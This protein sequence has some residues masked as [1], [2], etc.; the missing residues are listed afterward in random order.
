MGGTDESEEEREFRLR[1][2][3]L[4]V[5]DGRIFTSHGLSLEEVRMSFIVLALAGDEIKIPEDTAIVWEYLDKAWPRSVNG[6]PCFPSCHFMNIEDWKRAHA[7]ILA[8]MERRKS[9]KV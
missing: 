7:A 8:E 4:D 1:R 3:V 5:L 9:I 2:F 6:M